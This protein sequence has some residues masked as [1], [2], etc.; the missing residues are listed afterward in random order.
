MISRSGIWISQF[1]CLAS[2]P[3]ILIRLLS[4]PNTERAASVASCIAQSFAASESRMG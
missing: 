3:C 2:S 4:R 1:L